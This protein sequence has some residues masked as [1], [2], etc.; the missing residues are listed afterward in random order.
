MKTE[1]ELVE[2]KKNK[3]ET[4]EEVWRNLT[5]DIVFAVVYCQDSLQRSQAEAIRDHFTN[6]HAFA[7]ADFDMDIDAN[8]HE[9]EKLFFDKLG[10]LR[11][12]EGDEEEEEEE[13]KSESNDED[14]KSAGEKEEESKEPKP[15]KP[16]K[17]LERPAAIRKAYNDQFNN[18]SDESE[19]ED[20]ILDNLL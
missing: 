4:P 10:H 14:D 12:E 19:D 18:Y 16:V 15:L 20:K 11:R 6:V 9:S 7:D 8:F 17:F 13:K 5:P 1:A 3:E 2:A